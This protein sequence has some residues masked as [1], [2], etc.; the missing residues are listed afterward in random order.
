VE[1]RAWSENGDVLI[2]V[3]DTGPGITAADL[4]LIFDK[5]YRAKDGNKAGGIGLGLTL[6]QSIAE[7]H[8]G[9]ITVESQVGTGSSFTLRLPAAASPAVTAATEEATA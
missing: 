8:G 7:V 4:P 6:A 9:R 2:L 3:R 1:V 5:F